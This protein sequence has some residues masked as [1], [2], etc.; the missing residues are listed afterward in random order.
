MEDIRDVFLDAVRI[1]LRTD[2]PFAICLSGGVDSSNVAAAA[3]L[4]L[5]NSSHVT[6]YTLDPAPYYE[7]EIEFARE[8]A[9]GNGYQFKSV[10]LSPA[11]TWGEI[12]DFILTHEE[13]TSLG[14]VVQYILYREISQD[15][16]RV[17]LDG[18]GGDEAF[19]GYP[20]FYYT[21]IQDI[22]R[23]GRLGDL[24]RWLV[25]ALFNN[26]S[27]LLRVWCLGR[28][29]VNPY[30][31]F[32]PMAERLLD[33]LPQEVPW[34]FKE[35][36]AARSW[37]QRQ[38]AAYYWWELPVLLRDA[39]R[40]GMR[41]SLE[42]RSPFLDHRILELTH[43]ADPLDL[44]HDGWS[45]WIARR[46]I[47]D[48]RLPFH[49]KWFRRKRGFY[50]QPMAFAAP[51]QRA[52]R[53]LLPHVRQLPELLNM[54]ALSDNILSSS[55]WSVFNIIILDLSP[56]LLDIPREVK[57]VFERENL[58]FPVTSDSLLRRKQRWFRV[59]R[60]VMNEIRWLFMKG[61]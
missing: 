40:N 56:D 29:F 38:I 48:E 42:V 22:L 8:V 27:D 58:S 57:V 46:L 49:V 33:K 4:W 18:Q 1:A 30:L 12:V 20:W 50:I 7:S 35:V 5:R 19:A 51:V 52:I 6:A 2:A 31:H 15:K 13:P 14:S 3:G 43:N 34:A 45:K 9:Q 55:L 23:Q 26:N 61:G 44:M 54:S 59:K 36:C 41:W 28:Q 25:R 39:D 60:Y 11:L 24:F 10:P 53:L 37:R 17:L 16:I 21:I 47:E 32:N